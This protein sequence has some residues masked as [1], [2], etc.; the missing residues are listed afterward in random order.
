M[1][2]RENGKLVHWWEGKV[3][4]CEDLDL[5]LGNMI[6]KISDNVNVVMLL[7]VRRRSIDCGM[8][9]KV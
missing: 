6:K 4:R 9:Q 8:V 7:T 1:G 5:N 2:L 3:A